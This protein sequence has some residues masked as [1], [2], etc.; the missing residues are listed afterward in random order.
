M[1]VFMNV[2]TKAMTKPFA[3]LGS[4]FGGGDDLDHVTFDMG[5]ADFAEGETTKLDTLATAL[6]ERPALKL[7]IIGSID[8]IK[9]RT[10]L[11]K[12]KLERKLGELR[13]KELQAAGQKVSSVDSVRLTPEDHDRLLKLAYAEAVGLVSSKGSDPSS[14]KVT[15]HLMTKQNF[16]AS[17]QVK[18][19]DEAK[20][21]PASGAVSLA[22]MESKWLELVPI[23]PEDYK[24]LTDDRAAAV[25]SYLLQSGKV[26]TNRIAVTTSKTT[27]GGSNRANL[28]L[29]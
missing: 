6:Y 18:A 8:P 15:A 26:E 24:K 11:A 20:N 29:Q 27:E 28:T 9:D 1:Q 4:V 21:A 23:T 3:M 22:D 2:V 19:G 10:A 16:V 7:G 12:L 13:L 14:A 5:K 17:R 25:Q